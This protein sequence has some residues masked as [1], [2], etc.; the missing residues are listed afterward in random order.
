MKVKEG[1]IVDA[2]VMQTCSLQHFHFH[3]H[4]AP[5]TRE[6]SLDQQEIWVARRATHIAIGSLR[7]SHLLWSSA[8]HGLSLSSRFS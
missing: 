3:P 2:N 6:L 5:A 8:H 1:R 4:S 7:T